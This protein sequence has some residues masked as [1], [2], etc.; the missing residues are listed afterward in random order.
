MNFHQEPLAVALSSALQV[1]MAQPHG[2]SA[3]RGLLMERIA[4][5]SNPKKKQGFQDALDC[6]DLLIEQLAEVEIA[7]MK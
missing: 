3:L 5:S 1:L 6:C 2:V 4:Q 7:E